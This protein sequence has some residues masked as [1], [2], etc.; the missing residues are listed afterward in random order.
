MANRAKSSE[1]KVRTNILDIDLDIE[2]RNLAQGHCTQN[3]SML[4]FVKSEQDWVKEREYKV[5]IWI[6]KRFSP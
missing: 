2:Q 1:N 5:L 4:S 3:T 6:S